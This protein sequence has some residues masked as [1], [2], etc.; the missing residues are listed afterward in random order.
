[1]DKSNRGYND[2]SGAKI[3][4]KELRDRL[5]KLIVKLMIK[6][7]RVSDRLFWM[8]FFTI[9]ASHLNAVDCE[10]AAQHP[11]QGKLR[12]K[13]TGIADFT[14]ISLFIADVESLLR[15]M[16]GDVD[17]DA[18]DK[19]LRA[20]RTIVLKF[21]VSSHPDLCDEYYQAGNIDYI[22]G[23]G[24]PKGYGLSCSDHNRAAIAAHSLAIRILRVS[25]TPDAY[26]PYTN[27]FIKALKKHWPNIGG[28]EEEEEEES[29]YEIK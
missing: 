19:L 14:S 25:V 12:R 27:Q 2:S 22:N 26:S 18:L 5:W 29:Y 17:S 16:Y 15:E 21:T 4:L 9:E 3:R 28:G 23:I 13:K 8:I 10:V 11:F 20:V 1:M 6:S 7:D 24:A